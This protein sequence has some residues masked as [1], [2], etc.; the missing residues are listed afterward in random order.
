MLVDS[1]SA[2]PT[3]IFLFLDLVTPLFVVFLLKM[4]FR[5]QGLGFRVLVIQVVERR[6]VVSGSIP[7][8]WLCMALLQ[9]SPVTSSQESGRL[10]YIPGVGGFRLLFLP[11]C[12]Y[13]CM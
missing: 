1:W 5:L 7:D 2:M 13:V 12:M 6:M 8:I 11:V 3:S 10:L 4:R 9:G